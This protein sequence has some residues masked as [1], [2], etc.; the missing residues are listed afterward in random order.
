M[1]YVQNLLAVIRSTRAPPSVQIGSS[2]SVSGLFCYGF[3]LLLKRSFRCLA[4]TEPN[5]L[6]SHGLSK[7]A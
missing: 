1:G 6:N 5:E 4:A 7:E 2:Q 3:T